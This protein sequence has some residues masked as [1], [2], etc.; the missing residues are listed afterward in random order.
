MARQPHPAAPG[1]PLGG[2]PR[3]SRS[4]RD[5][6]RVYVTNSL[7]AAWD[8]VF[9]PEDVGAWLAKIDADTSSGGMSSRCAFLCAR[10]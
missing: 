4:A 3:W 9:Y 2:G 6:T 5:G 7:Y 1:G 10:G 8:E